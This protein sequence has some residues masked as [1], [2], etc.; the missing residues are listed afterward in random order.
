MDLV[1]VRDSEGRLEVVLDRTVGVEV[2]SIRRGVDVGGAE[3]V[4]VERTVGSILGR[5]NT[6]G[7]EIVVRGPE[8]IGGDTVRTEGG[9]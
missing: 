6:L 1:D 7:L 9:E 4:V 2:D 8:S 5:S 3:V